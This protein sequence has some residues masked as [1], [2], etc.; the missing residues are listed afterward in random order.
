MTPAQKR[1]AALAGLMLVLLALAA[2]WSTLRMIDRRDAAQAG[3]RELAESKRIARQIEAL[4]ERDAVA[5]DDPDSARQEENLAQQIDQAAQAVGLVG[6]WRR[7][8]D[9]KPSRR[10]GDTPYTRK[11]AVLLTR[12]LTLDQLGALAHELT[13]DSPL[14]VS[15]LRLTTPSGETRGN[16]WDADVTLTYLIYD[17]PDTDR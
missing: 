12:G 4:R 6:D 7:G 13:Y 14:T 3:A 16:R 1:Q 10:V 17:P 2:G 5:S 15:E 11:P 9:H 8:I